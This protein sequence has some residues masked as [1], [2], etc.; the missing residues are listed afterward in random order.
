ML[1]PSFA[2]ARAEVVDLLEDPIRGLAPDGDGFP[3]R[4]RPFEIVTVRFGTR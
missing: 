4:V 2:V 3:L 1:Q